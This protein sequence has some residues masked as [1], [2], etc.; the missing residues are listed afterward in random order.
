MVPRQ[1]AGD[2]V[3]EKGDEPRE[4]PEIGLGP[5]VPPVD[6]DDIGHGL[7]GVKRD[8]GGQDHLPESAQKQAGVFEVEEQA[9]VA[10]Q[11]DGQDG[12]AAPGGRG[13]GDA[14]GQEKIQDRGRQHRQEK[15]GVPRESVEQK[16]GKRHPA[17]EGGP[18][19]QP[20]SQ[21]GAGQKY[22]DE[23]Q[24]IEK[25]A[26]VHDTNFKLDLDETPFSI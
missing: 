4:L 14:E 8:P 17:Q 25:H 16:A 11:G 12:L 24:R 13:P 2:Q 3:G 10:G 6:V 18:A 9:Q 26:P 22:E 5:G 21:Q 19:Q 7:E 15:P 1:G 20:R 23:L